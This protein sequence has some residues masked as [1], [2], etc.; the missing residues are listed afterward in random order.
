[1]IKLSL[2]ALILAFS[3]VQADIRRIHY[4]LATCDGDSEMFVHPVGKCD[5]HEEASSPGKPRYVMHSCECSTWIPCENGAS[6]CWQ[7]NVGNATS[8]LY[9][10]SECKTEVAGVSVQRKRFGK[11]SYY[12]DLLGRVTQ[13]CND[14]SCDECPDAGPSPAEIEA[15]NIGIGVGVG[16]GVAVLL[17]V[18][19]GGF[20]CYRRR[21]ASQGAIR[22]P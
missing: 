14:V 4:N 20:I 15:R 18:A 3:L 12:F 10:D 19:V 17:A 1:M 5:E 22:L 21:K 16:V 6:S 11:S 2:F 13:G 8:R 9:E 7:L